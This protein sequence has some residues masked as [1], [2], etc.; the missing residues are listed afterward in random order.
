VIRRRDR[1]STVT[2]PFERTFRNYEATRPAT[3]SAQQA[4]FNFCGCGWPEHLLC[5]KGLPEGLKSS[6]FVMVSNYEEDRVSNNDMY[7]CTI[8]SQ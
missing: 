5:P 3:G 2:I 1:E 7:T 8:I 4:E 6:L